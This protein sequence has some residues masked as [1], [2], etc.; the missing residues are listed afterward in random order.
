MVGTRGTR[1]SARLRKQKNTCLVGDSMEESVDNRDEQ[2]EETVEGEDNNAGE[3]GENA[4]EENEPQ[5]NDIGCKSCL[6]E[7]EQSIETH[8]VETEYDKPNRTM[9]YLQGFAKRV[10][11]CTI[12]VMI[13]K[14]AW[15]RLQP[16]VWPEEPIKEG[17]LY[18]LTDRSFRGHISRGDHFVMM[19]APW[20]G[21]C[22][23]LKPDWEKLAKNSGVK[24]TKIGKVDC[25]ANKDV[26]KKY[27]VTGYPTLLYFRNGNLVENYKGAKTLDGLKEYLKTMKHK[28]NTNKG[29]EKPTSDKKPKP[30]TTDKKPKPTASTSKPPK[31]KK[32][33]SVKPEL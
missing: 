11:L 5:K 17:K 8:E 6:Q 13:G 24:D 7:G 3:E 25:T 14:Y 15:P 1:T 12:L 32:K 22:A 33:E 28:E 19:Y 4:T 31:K 16:I 10:V 18:V 2:E 26:C 30:T 20:C 29:K 9:R 23:R 27:D 21:H